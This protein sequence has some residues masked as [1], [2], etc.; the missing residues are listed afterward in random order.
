MNRKVCIIGLDCAPPDLVFEKWRKELPVLSGLM[1]KGVYGPL[2]STIPP[3][4]IPAWTSMVTSKNPGKLG[5]YGFRNRQD[6]S[7]EKM[8]F[9]N[10]LLVKEDTLWDILARSRKKVTLIGIPQTYPPRPVNG[11]MITCFLTPDTKSRYTY[12]ESLKEEI[13]SWVGEYIIDVDKYRTEEKDK[14]LEQIYEMTKKQFKVAGHLLTEKE[15]DFFMMVVM[16]IDRIHHGFWKFHDPGHIKFEPGSKYEN[17]THDYYIYVDQSIGELLSHIDSETTVLVVSDHGAKAM[18]GGVCVNEWLMEKG[19]LHLKEKPVG[20][21]PFGKAKVDWKRTVAWGE[22]GYYSRIFLNVKG[23]EPEGVIDP[24]DYE[25]VRE[26]L[27]KSLEAI[28]DGQGINIGT[29]VYKPEEIYSEV[30][31]IPP[32]L[33]VY[34]GNL[35]WRSVGSIGLGSIL[36]FENDTGPDDANHDT[37]G[38]FIMGGANVKARGLREG[39]NLLD[40]APT[41]LNLMG[42]EVPG[43]M[44]G[45]VIEY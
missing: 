37:H 26:D 21:I 28:T 9:A 27:R 19:Y 15:W 33:I 1:E 35:S 24:S 43:D 6:Y 13:R 40:V 11:H 16:G 8:I 45:K 25:R 42:I 32:D 22:G 41:V 29:K 14:L 31:R 7:Y 10:S 17:A 30:R 3:I 5:L 18:V 36:T 2:E 12:P 4:T 38:I 20:V 34:F 44:E 23:R 39:L